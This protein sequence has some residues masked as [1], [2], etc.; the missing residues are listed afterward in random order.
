MK[1]KVKDL[2]VYYDGKRYEKDETL[3]IKDA[4]FNETLFEGVSTPRKRKKDE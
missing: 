1:V 2:A 4:H 3:D